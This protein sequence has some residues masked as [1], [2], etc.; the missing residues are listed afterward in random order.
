[1]IGSYVENL[2]RILAVTLLVSC[3]DTTPLAP[4]DPDDDADAGRPD[5]PAGD[6]SIDTPCRRCITGEDSV[7]F[8]LY[9]VCLTTP[10]C[11]ELSDCLFQEHC[12][13]VPNFEDRV[14]CALPCADKVGIQTGT[15]PAIPAVLD[16]N[17]CSIANCLEE[18]PFQP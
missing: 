3:V 1:M 11:P 8:P 10:L 15:D 4:T 16:I 13:E 12:Y 6:G 17:V 2:S 14:A 18:C 9:Q 5:G 7:C